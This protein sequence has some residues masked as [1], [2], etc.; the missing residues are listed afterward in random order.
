MKV[1]N[2]INSKNINELAEWL[3]KFDEQWLP[4]WDTWYEHRYCDKCETIVKSNGYRDMEYSWC[5]LHNGKCKFFQDMYEVP[6]GKQLIK[7]WLESED[8]DGV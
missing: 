2:S 6:Y 3:C 1:F 4:P 7:M 5:E 8:N